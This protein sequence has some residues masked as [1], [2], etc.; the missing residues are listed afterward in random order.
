MANL[1]SRIRGDRS[2]KDRRATAPTEVPAPARE[3]VEETPVPATHPPLSGGL[4]ETPESLERNL[5][6]R[7][8][9]LMDRAGAGRGK[10]DEAALVERLLLGAQDVIRQ[11]PDAARKAL[12]VC[13]DPNSSTRELVTL[14]E[15]DPG[16]SQALLRRANS[17]WF[18][19]GNGAIVSI[20]Q[21]VQRMGT[22]GVES[23]LLENIIHGLVS[24]PGPAYEGM[25]TAS[26]T[27]LLN[28]ALIARTIAPS[29]QV[30]PDTAHSL[31]L[32]HDV[33]RLVIFDRISEMRKERRRDVA[34]SPKFLD[35]VLGRLHEPLGGQAALL[36]GLGGDVAHAVANHHRQ[37][38]AA[39]A[40]EPLTEL[41]FVADR[42]E[43]SRSRATEP[44]WEAIWRE[45]HLLAPLDLVASNVMFT[46]R[47]DPGEQ[48]KAA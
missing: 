3:R 38:P 28:T 5:K 48:R 20:T 8:S 45:G 17:A 24:R 29:F 44:D 42:L 46:A 40:F 23:V 32:F 10:E 4:T 21:G 6:W 47:E 16:L 2:A 11:L 35:G 34:L 30:H 31:G 19:R 25:V 41:L 33:G 15:G 13:R 14:F 7:A 39:D 18:Q 9:V 22:K 37:R 27:H 43:H 36:W 12:A 1:W 26:W